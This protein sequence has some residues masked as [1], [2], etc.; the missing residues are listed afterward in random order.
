MG[1]ASSNKKVNRAASTGGGRTARG[2]TPILWYSTIFLAVVVGIMGVYVSATSEKIRPSQAAADVPPR[3]GQD[4]WHAAYG[5]YVC[6]AW[7]PG[8]TDANSDRYGIHSHG[9]GLIHTH[10]AVKSAAGKGATLGKFFEEVDAKVTNSSISVPKSSGA[11]RLAVKNGDKCGKDKG[12]V[13]AVVFKNAADTKG[14]PLKGN[15][16]DWRIQNGQIVAV[17]FVAT[18]TQLQPPPSVANLADPTDV[19]PSDGAPPAPSDGAPPAPEGTPPAE[20]TATTAA[21]PGA[22]TAP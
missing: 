16:N 4:H 17:G 3:L 9:D 15:P 21:T 18:G 11:K 12:E 13:K 7:V 8:L 19:G 10:P 22:T 1:R 5:I 20:G 14:T 2:R 6:D